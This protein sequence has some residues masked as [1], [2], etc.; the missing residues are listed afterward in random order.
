MALIVDKGNDESVG[1]C[2][3]SITGE[4]TIYTIDE[5][6]QKMSA[7][8]HLYERFEISL[9]DL[10]EID[11]AGIQLLLALGRELRSQN[12][13][14]KL[15]AMSGNA[16]HLIKTYDVYERLFIGVAENE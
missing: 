12:K 16:N 11:S 4:F 14:L 10:E 8:L 6:K 9:A 3:F 15:T 1:L 5:I 2:A 7:Y 13:T